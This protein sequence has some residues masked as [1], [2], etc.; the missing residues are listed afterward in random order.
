VSRNLILFRFHSVGYRTYRVN[1]FPVTGQ[2]NTRWTRPGTNLK[3][4]TELDCF[5]TFICRLKTFEREN[6]IDVNL[7]NVIRYRTL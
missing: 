5:E 3:L 6:T 2:G 7:S 4:E 1:D